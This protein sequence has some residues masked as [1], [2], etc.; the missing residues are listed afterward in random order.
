MFGITRRDWRFGNIRLGDFAGLVGFVGTI[1][2]YFLF[3]R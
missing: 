3:F 1:A 2:V